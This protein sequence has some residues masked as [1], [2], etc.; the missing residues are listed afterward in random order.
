MPPLPSLPLT[1]PVHVFGMLIVIILLAPIVFTR[2]RVPPIVGLILF[3]AVVGPGLLGVLER[4]ATIELLGMVGLLFL[5]F[6][7]GLSMDLNQFEKQ[8][9]R[10]IIFGLL[11]FTI[12]QLM[13][14]AV[15]IYLLGYG[16]L[17]ALLLGAIVG[18]H[19]LLAYP[20]AARLGI[21]RNTSVTMT[22]GGTM[23]TDALSLTL[24]AVVV[25][26]SA[27]SI[28]L[29]F[30]LQFAAL[31]AVFVGVLFF[32]GPRIVRAGFKVT[33]DQPD[34]A[35]VLLLSLLFL[36][37]FG[38]GLVGLAPI[39]GAFLFG[40]AINRL[41]PDEG[42]LMS[43]IR[44]MGD[45]LFIPLFLISV[46]MLVDVR[47]L[48]A[49]FEVWI[50]AL[51]FTGLVILGKMAAAAFVAAFYKY[52]RDEMITV[53]GLSSPQ[54]AATLAVTLV[55]FEIG[56]FDAL[57]VNGVV[58]M[59]LIT[60]MIGPYLVEKF[61]RR[62]AML[63]EAR[64]YEP[65]QA[66]ERILIPIANPDTAHPLI[67]LAIGVYDR[68][69]GEPVY[70]AAIARDDD[71]TQQNVAACER[72]LSGAVIQLSRGDVPVV[73]ITRVAE[74][75]V[76]GLQR[77]IVERRASMIVM[78]WAGERDARG[79][80]LSRVIDRVLYGSQASVLVSRLYGDPVSAGRLIVC[81]PPLADRHPEFGDSLAA[82]H[83]L[84]RAQQLEIVY[85]VPAAM[86]TAMRALTK[87]VRP[88][89]RPAFHL[90]DAWAALTGE[91][92]SLVRP[93]DAIVLSAARQGSV[94]WRAS[95]DRLPLQLARQF[96]D[97]NLIISYPI[98]RG[99]RR[100]RPALIWDRESR[101]QQINKT[102]AGEVTEP[103][104]RT[105]MA[106]T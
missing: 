70:P 73:P 67:G 52:N 56:L 105:E 14:L 36:A 47:V 18:S 4:D 64:P 57:A 101:G 89:L 54:A 91:L 93:G 51:T 45:A 55:G 34:R 29:T 84:A 95:L 48:I 8:K 27:G 68:K 32:L 3:G 39:I 60:C 104:S 61:G 81:V 46:G 1:D 13:A 106:E 28:G 72:L 19:T 7:A 83:R 59:I 66:P 99:T 16:V 97:N 88:D 82:L 17:P 53:F 33:G 31:A 85:V 24:L 21:T 78:G 44:F 100:R 80:V 43:R 76:D 71:R 26:A 90:L 25:A 94:A 23:V 96:R 40:V 92:Q 65:S 35:F 102:T 15:G 58:V 86:E 20:I 5:M 103:I 37:A 10:S 2:L 87:Q 79:V 41:V 49:G 6:S 38:A 22:M 75:I 74:D 69:S 77:A 62:V 42:S 9:D 50:V 98:D 63:E 11:S 12:P 30:W